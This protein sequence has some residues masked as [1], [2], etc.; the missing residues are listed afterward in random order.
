MQIRIV[1]TQ[2][3][4][5]TCGAGDNFPG[6]VNIHVGVQRK[7]RRDE[8]LDLQPGDAASVEWAVDCSVN[9][10]DVRGSYIQGRPG[11]RFI[12]LS[13]G[14]VGDEGQFSLFRRAKLLLADVPADV[15]DAAVSSGA[16]V[17][18]LGLTD[19]KGHPLL[20]ACEAAA[21]SLEFSR[22]ASYNRVVCNF[23]SRLAFLSS[24]RGRG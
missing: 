10:K 3:P 18:I 8:L 20:R 13:W 9:G 6:Y 23:C 12:Y 21:D 24:R 2:L 5:R 17:G 11:E 14:T 1:G 16:L 4:G 7:N 15:F 19:A 22:I